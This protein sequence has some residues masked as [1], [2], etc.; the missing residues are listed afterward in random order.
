[1][2][3]RDAERER[4]GQ[5]NDEEGRDGRDYVGSASSDYARGRSRREDYFGGYAQ[6]Y[7]RGTGYGREEYGSTRA[8]LK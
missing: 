4:F 2:A 5:L 3:D 6:P 7:G 8:G 1:M